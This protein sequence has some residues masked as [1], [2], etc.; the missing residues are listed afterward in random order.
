MVRSV[1]DTGVKE[2]WWN[3]APKDNLVNLKET[4]ASPWKGLAG[5]RKQRQ[6]TIFYKPNRIVSVLPT[7]C[8]PVRYWRRRPRGVFRDHRE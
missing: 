5:C 2:A 1:G 6:P 4:N 8:R 3:Q 7:H